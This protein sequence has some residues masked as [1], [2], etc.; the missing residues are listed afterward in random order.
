MVILIADH[1]VIVA[2]KL[3]IRLPKTV[4]MFSLET[5]CSPCLSRLAYWMVQAGFTD[6]SVNPVM[7]YVGAFVVEVTCYLA[8]TPTIPFSQL[9]DS[10]LL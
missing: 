1:P 9:D 7:V 5:F 10:F 6:Y 4:A 3:K 8:G 2:A